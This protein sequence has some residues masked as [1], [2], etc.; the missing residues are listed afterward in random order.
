MDD[1]SEI[2]Q[3]KPATKFVIAMVEVVSM[4]KKEN[5]ICSL[6]KSKFGVYEFL[7]SFSRWDDWLFR[8]YPGGRM[9]LSVAGEKRLEE[10]AKKAAGS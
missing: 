5:R 6:Y 1:L 3:K 2:L 10:D 9:V 8:A 7:A 4:A